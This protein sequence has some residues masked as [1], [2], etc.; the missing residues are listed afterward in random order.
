MGNVNG[1]DS[2]S[3]LSKRLKKITSER[4]STVRKQEQSNSVVAKIERVLFAYRET[5]AY[6]QHMLDQFEEE[7][8]NHGNRIV[9]SDAMYTENHQL[10]EL[11]D[12]IK[13]CIQEMEQKME[14]FEA[15]GSNQ[16]NALKEAGESQRNAME[17][18]I[19]QIRCIS[20]QQVREPQRGEIPVMMDTLT[21]EEDYA[22]TIDD[23]EDMIFVDE[24]LSFKSQGK[25]SSCTGKTEF[26]Q[27]QQSIL[28]EIEELK[29]SVVSMTEEVGQLTN[30]IT[31]KVAEDADE[32]SEEDKDDYL[33]Q[34]EAYNKSLTDIKR[35]LDDLMRFV[36]K[37]DGSI[38]E[39]LKSHTN[40]NRDA[41]L[42]QLQELKVITENR[43][44]GIKPL[45][46][47][48]LIIGI[49]GVG[50]LAFLIL[51][52]LGILNL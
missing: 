52:Y 39:S 28:R 18:Y 8:V 2:N 40:G 35:R 14:D 11:V 7:Y 30:T 15:A 17:S 36:G 24:S 45:L 5:L 26:N 49:L 22:T 44:K 3:L 1:Q 9:S 51:E 16:L 47:F 19:Q 33:V 46:V 41:V 27:T 4:Q 31:A 32:Y 13:A 34:M 21:A 37:V 6:Y 50:G 20:E 10:Q 12:Q 42:Q 25:S 38:I 23:S 29:A 43:N 48:N